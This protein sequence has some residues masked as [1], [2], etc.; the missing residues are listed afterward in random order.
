MA[1]QVN[2]SA[3]FVKCYLPCEDFWRIDTDE[4]TKYLSPSGSSSPQQQ[5]EA[6][7][8][9]QEL[10][11]DALISTFGENCLANNQQSSLITYNNLD[12]QTA[13]YSTL[14]FAEW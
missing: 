8:E 7:T 1:A 6:H 14:T 12:Q 4:F 5:R 3:S 13:I 10:R 2:I 11:D 9:W